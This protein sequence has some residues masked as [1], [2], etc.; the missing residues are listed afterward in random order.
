MVE[1]DEAEPFYARDWLAA[2]GLCTSWVVAAL[3]FALA[4]FYAYKILF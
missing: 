4:C 2:L 1:D 3:L